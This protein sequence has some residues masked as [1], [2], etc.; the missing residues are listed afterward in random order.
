MAK[1]HFY[2][3]TEFIDKS[4]SVDLISIGLVS[5]SGSSYYAVS[6]AFKEAQA[7]NWVKTNIF[8][9]LPPMSERKPLHQIRQEIL[10]FYQKELLRMNAHMGVFWA[11][12]AAHDWVLFCW[13]MGGMMHMHSSLPHV[14]FDLKQE[15]ERLAM[16]YDLFPEH[17]NKHHALHDAMW[18]R[19]LHQQLQR[20]EFR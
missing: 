10:S 11:Y 8:P 13:L 14:C 16:P 3:D 17:D 12:F 15:V 18:N 1:C 9:M 20:F 4:F 2:L 7:S 5:E 19:K 6:N